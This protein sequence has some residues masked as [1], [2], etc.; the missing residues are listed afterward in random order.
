MAYGH[1]PLGPGHF[2]GVVGLPSHPICRPRLLRACR[3]IR[4]QRRSSASLTDSRHESTNSATAAAKKAAVQV[5][6][7]STTKCMTAL[8]VRLDRMPRT[9]SRT[10]R[11]CLP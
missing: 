6:K 8:S 5:L 3:S 9:I 2:Q 7:L 1:P 4:H 10:T 11:A